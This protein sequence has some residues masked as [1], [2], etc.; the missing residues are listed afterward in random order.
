MGRIVSVHSYRGG[1]GKSNITANLA[2]LVAKRGKHVA[3]LDTDIQSPGVHLIFGLDGQRLVY[4]LSDFVFGRCELAETVYDVS[5]QIGLGAGAGRVYL[6]PSS[7]A[8]DDISRII[9]EGYDVNRFSKEFRRLIAEL[10]LDY[11]FLDTHPGLNRETLLTIAISDEL[12]I[13]LRPDTQDYHGTAVL[14][15]VASRLN[16]PRIRMVVNKVVNGM[17]AESVRTHVQAA[18]GHAVI[19]VLPL[20]ESMAI[21]GSRELFA[22][23]HPEHPLTMALHDVTDDLTNLGG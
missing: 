18:Y 20:D 22:H 10:D 6:L 11:L 21:V 7:M 23:I 13:L 16:V 2:Y 19:G 17:T 14:L 8:V 15:E 12:L 3:V 9:A 5:R 1:T 4:T